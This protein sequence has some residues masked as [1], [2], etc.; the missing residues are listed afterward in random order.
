MDR[1]SDSMIIVAGSGQESSSVFIL[2][3][4]VSDF[5]WGLFESPIVS[6][7]FSPLHGCN[8][9]LFQWS[10]SSYLCDYYILLW[11]CYM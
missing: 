9:G 11:C 5:P 3:A 4:I 8:V 2:S 1:A 7:E 10:F 6:V